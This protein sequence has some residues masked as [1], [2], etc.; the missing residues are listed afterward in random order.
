MKFILN[1]IYKCSHYIQ[2]PLNEQ[3]QIHKTCNKCMKKIDSDKYDEHENQREILSEK[4]GYSLPIDPLEVQYCSNCGLKCESRRQLLKHMKVHKGGTFSCDQCN[5]KCKTTEDL[6]QHVKRYHV[7]LQCE[8]CGQK[9]IGKQSLA[10]HIS[11][12]GDP[13]LPNENVEKKCST[14]NKVCKH[15]YH[16]KRHLR[17][18]EL[19][20]VFF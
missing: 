17:T 12:H 11:K 19:Q 3:V 13:L 5:K 20:R 15:L 8:I 18:H 4:K 7:T 1:S 16:L 9:I 2:K 14:C 6:K 10:K